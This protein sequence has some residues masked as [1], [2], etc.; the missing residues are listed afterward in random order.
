MLIT[1]NAIEEYLANSNVGIPDGHHV[2]L[3]VAVDSKGT[4]VILAE[5]LAS[6]WKATQNLTFMPHAEGAKFDYGIQVT[7][8]W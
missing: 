3:V 5:N 2:A 1:K 7:K 6:G 4:R 8:T